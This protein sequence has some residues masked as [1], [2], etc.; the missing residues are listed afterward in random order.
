[1]FLNDFFR[2]NKKK[3]RVGRGQ[4][5]GLGKTS[6][7]GHKGQNSRSGGLRK[8]WF[9]GGQTPLH[10]RLPKFGFVSKK[11][12]KIKQ[13]NLN[14]I[15]SCCEREINIQILKKYKIIKNSV[16][17]VKIILSNNMLAEKIKNVFIFSGI[18]VSKNVKKLILVN[19][20]SV[21]D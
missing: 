7:R 10:I 14:F 13:L 11:N 19:G 5:S 20:G 17:N 4:G 21:I 12:K 1:M 18:K 3:V 9:E 15:K 6:G 2:I 16:K 8:P